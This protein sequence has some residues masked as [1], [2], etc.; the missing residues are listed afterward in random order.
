MNHE[1]LLIEGCKDFNHILSDEQIK[2]FKQYYELLVTYNEK[3]NL[4]RI[5]EAGDVYIKHFLDSISVCTGYDFDTKKTVVDVG[6][7]AG[8]PGFP[9][10]IA[11]PNIELTAIDALNKR[12][13][14]LEEVS[15]TLG[16]EDVTCIHSRAE[17]G[18]M[19]TS[20]REQFDVCVSRAV[21]ELSV[22]AEYC[23][24]FV[25]VGGQFVSLK[26][27]A[28]V[29]ELENAQNAIATLG[30]E[31]VNVQ[32]VNIPFSDLK[33]KLVII[34]KVKETPLKYPRKPSKIKKRPL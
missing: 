28:A 6:T 31:V 14:F 33:H 19:D 5:I 4:T 3:M 32:D 23:L 9:L 22:L 11:F 25:K 30:G 10:K 17:D 21:A 18:A 20:L 16:L 34:N 7:G 27:P 24:P 15:D 12:V 1:Q 29:E 13:K 8:F 2:Q 26:G